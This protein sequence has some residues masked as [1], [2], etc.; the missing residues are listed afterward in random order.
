MTI[1]KDEDEW[2]DED[3]NESLVRKINE[4]S[5][6]ELKDI[7]SQL[8]PS[9]MVTDKHGYALTLPQLISGR[10]SIF[11]YTIPQAFHAQSSRDVSNSLKIIWKICISMGYDSLIEDTKHPHLDGLQNQNKRKCDS[12]QVDFLLYT[13]Q[14]ES[15]SL[16]S[17]AGKLIQ[18]KMKLSYT[19][20]NTMRTTYLVVMNYNYNHL[21]NKAD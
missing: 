5:L 10:I 7:I 14:M 21:N 16:V 9:F 15:K 1:D 18:K 3:P 19:G 6:S 17:S 13:A 20:D 2:V 8:I 11:V 12:Q 4:L